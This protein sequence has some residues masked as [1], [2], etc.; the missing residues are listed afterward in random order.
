M[1]VI[2]PV[3]FTERLIMGI[4]AMSVKPIEELTGCTSLDPPQ[5]WANSP[6]EPIAYDGDGDDDDYG[7]S[8]DDDRD[9]DDDLFDDEDDLED[10]GDLDDEDDDEF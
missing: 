3:L 9:D 1:R 5:T 6:A 10:D 2:T 8:R 7:P 4:K